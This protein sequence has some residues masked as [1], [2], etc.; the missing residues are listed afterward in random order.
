MTRRQKIILILLLPFLVVTILRETGS[1]SLNLYNSR[2]TSTTS[3][4]WSDFTGI[5][6][7]SVQDLK[8]MTCVA[9]D[10]L[11]GKPLLVYCLGQKYGEQGTKECPPVAV[12]IHRIDHGPL[13][14]PLYKSARFHLVV[15]VTRSL[16]AYRQDGDSIQLY[17]YQLSGVITLNGELTVIGL[18]SYRQAE[19]LLASNVMVSVYNIMR[20]KLDATK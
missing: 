1:L 18:C 5:V 2:A 15:P 11:K 19:S 6:K 20:A 4:T 16:S 9:D 3:T 12:F 10:G 14:T 13:W 17:N 7:I 8:N